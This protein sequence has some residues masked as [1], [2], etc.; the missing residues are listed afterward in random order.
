[1]GLWLWPAGD[2][3]GDPESVAL[4]QLSPMVSGCEDVLAECSWLL[5]HSGQQCRTHGR[6]WEKQV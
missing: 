5:E 2:P 4:D 3:A 1:M 6:V